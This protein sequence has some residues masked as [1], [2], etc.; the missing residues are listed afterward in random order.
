MFIARGRHHPQSKGI[1]RASS[2]TILLVAARSTR[3]KRWAEANEQSSSPRIQQAEAT[4]HT[5][6]PCQ[7]TKRRARMR[8][9]IDLPSKKCPVCRRQFSWRRK[10]AR[11][12]EQVTYCSKRCRDTK[13]KPLQR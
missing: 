3:L 2:T 10:W 5:D 12:W 7:R 4:T 13:G 11:N 8:R 9:K 6:L 1:P